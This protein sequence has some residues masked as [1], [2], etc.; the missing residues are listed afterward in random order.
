MFSIPHNHN[1]ER[2][3]ARLLSIE[4]CSMHLISLEAC[5][6]QQGTIEA[7]A[8]TSC[9]RSLLCEAMTEWYENNW[10]NKN[11]SR[12]SNNRDGTPGLPH[13][14]PQVQPRLQLRSLLFLCHLSLAANFGTGS[15]VGKPGHQL[16]NEVQP[17][18]WSRKQS[19]LDPPQRTSDFPPG[20]SESS[21]R[22]LCEG[23]YQG[24]VWTQLLNRIREMDLDVDEV[25]RASLSRKK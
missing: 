5:L 12:W 23:R 21:S 8:V 22:V 1:P 7:S 9:H 19:F 13:L 6:A 2:L 15:P 18:E 3:A 14:L 20:P 11:D 25:A 16:F 24:V 10:D 17:T 4:S